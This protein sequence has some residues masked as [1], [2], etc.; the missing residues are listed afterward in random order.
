MAGRSFKRKAVKIK[1]FESGKFTVLA[2]FGN[3]AYNALLLLR[4]RDGGWA[5]FGWI[6]EAFADRV[7]IAVSFASQAL[8]DD[9]R[10]KIRAVIF[11]AEPAPADY[12][13]AHHIFEI[14]S[15]AVDA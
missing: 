9:D 13:Q 15:G 1:V 14:V 10:F 12:L 8:S 4:F 11:G 2:E 6:T 7:L 3:D 5:R